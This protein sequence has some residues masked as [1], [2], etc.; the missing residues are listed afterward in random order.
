MAVAKAHSLAVS[1]SERKMTLSEVRPRR[2]VVR[3]WLYRGQWNRTCSLVCRYGRY[4]Y[5][6]VNWGWFGSA[7]GHRVGSSAPCLKRS[8]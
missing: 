3:A 6:G 2:W 5:E 7:H 4:G 1:S 8:E